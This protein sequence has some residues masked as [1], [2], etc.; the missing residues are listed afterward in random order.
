MTFQHYDKHNSA[1]PRHRAEF[2][3]DFVAIVLLAVNRQH[4]DIHHQ[5]EARQKT[6]THTHTHTH[7]QIYLQIKLGSYFPLQF[8]S[9]PSRIQGQVKALDT[10]NAS[11]YR[12]WQRLIKRGVRKIS[13]HFH[14]TA[15]SLQQL[16][17]LFKD[18][19]SLLQTIP[20]LSQPVWFKD[21]SSRP[22]IQGRHGKY[23]TNSQ[24]QCSACQPPRI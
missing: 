13:I 21:I 19:F 4:S 2:G 20:G 14:Q 17:K 8:E 22:W 6:C 23:T 18:L 10:F 3:E 7:P 9:L 16:S 12:I 11:K 15:D 1:I 24:Q 5:S